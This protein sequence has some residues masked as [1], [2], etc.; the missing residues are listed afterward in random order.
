VLRSDPQKK[1]GPYTV[2]LR[3]RILLVKGNYSNGKKSGLW[4][5]FDLSGRVDERYNYDQKKYTFEGPF[6]ESPDFKYLFDDSLKMGDRLT[7]PLKIGGIYFGFIP[8]LNI[9]RVPFETYNIDTD[10]FMAY[11]ELLISPMGQLADYN[12][13]LVS[14]YYQYDQTFNMATSLFSKEDRTFVP[15]TLNGMPVMSRI[16]ITCYITPRGGLDFF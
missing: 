2:F 12:I 11:I 4:Q 6:Y 15:A 8:Y 10:A 7:R 9:F 1:V 14:N 13:R 3:R 16:I 5:F